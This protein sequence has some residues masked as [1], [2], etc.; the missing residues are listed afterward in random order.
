V[1]GLGD[2]HEERPASARVCAKAL[3]WHFHSTDC[4][5]SVATHPIDITGVAATTKTAAQRLWRP[6]A[7]CVCTPTGAPPLALQ[8]G[9]TEAACGAPA[10]LPCGVSVAPEPRRANSRPPPPLRSSPWLPRRRANLGDPAPSSVP[11]R[12]RAARKRRTRT[13]S[14]ASASAAAAQDAA[15]AVG[16]RRGVSRR[17]AHNA[18]R[19]LCARFGGLTFGVQRTLQMHASSSFDQVFACWPPMLVMQ[20]PAR[21]AGFCAGA[22]EEPAGRRR[23]VA[24]GRG[25]VPGRRAV[26]RH[27]AGRRPRERAAARLRLCCPAG[28]VRR[29]A[30]RARPRRR[31]PRRRP[32]RRARARARSPRARR[33]AR[34]PACTAARWSHSGRPPAGTHQAPVRRSRAVATQ[35]RCGRSVR[36]RRLAS[37]PAM[38]CPAHTPDNAQKRIRQRAAIV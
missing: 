23:D 5:A 15:T 32:R 19:R 3:V 37:W 31:R 13:S 18:I 16:A 34:S 22:G 33:S 38:D 24:A 11:V 29:A 12:L 2:R 36:L 30:A 7:A 1:Y 21:A 8:L 6:L 10:G 26:R 27:A 4:D 17:A 9:G 25:P 35:Q 28:S 20:Q 14:A